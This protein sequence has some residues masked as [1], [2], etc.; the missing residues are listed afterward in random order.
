[1]SDFQKISS[2]DAEDGVCNK[3][4]VKKMCLT[5]VGRESN[6][7]LLLGRQQC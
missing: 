7:D 2:A 5:C 1:M 6:P 4:K 3:K